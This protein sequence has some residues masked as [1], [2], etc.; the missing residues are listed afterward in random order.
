M[1]DPKRIPVMLE[2]I[3]VLWE[4]YPDL[5]LGQLIENVRG[6]SGLGEVDLFYI[7]DDRMEQALDEYGM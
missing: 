7:E 4:K 6:Q 5:R 2:K 3:R 1:R